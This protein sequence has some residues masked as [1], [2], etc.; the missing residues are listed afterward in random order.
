MS[1][2]IGSFSDPSYGPDF[3]GQLFGSLEEAK[4]MLHRAHYSGDSYRVARLNLDGEMTYDFMP[5]VSREAT[6]FLYV[7]DKT[8]KP[9]T[10]YD[11]PSYMTYIG[12]R[13]AVRTVKL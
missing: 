4:D 8:D 6:I 1:V 10:E 11:Y 2:Y 5:C 3:E 12:S 9:V 7:W 13:G